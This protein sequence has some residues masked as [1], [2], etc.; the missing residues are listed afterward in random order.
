MPNKVKFNLK[1]VYYA[2]V[3][4]AAGEGGATTYTYGTPVAWPGAVSLSLDAEGDT[5]T[6]YADGIAFYVTT[7]NNGYSGDFESA[8]VPESFKT[9]ILK[10][11]ANQTDGTIV[12]YSTAEPA[13]FALLFQFDGDQ[14]ATKHVLYNCKCTRPSIASQTNEESK[15]VQTETLSITAAPRAD[16]LVKAS[17]NS[18]SG[19]AYSGWFSNVYVP[20]QA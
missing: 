2:T 8:L 20:T 13:A 14:N 18:A 19:S 17:A 4:E 3:T 6:F 10:E 5:S 12:E 15:E 9:D 16:G 1:N 11:V 7:A